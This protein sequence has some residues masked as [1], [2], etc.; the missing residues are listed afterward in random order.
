MVPP[1]VLTSASASAGWRSGVR[2]CS[3]STPNPLAATMQ[4]VSIQRREYPRPKKSPIVRNAPA[5]SN[6]G[7]NPETGRS[8][9]GDT[10]TAIMATSNSH[11]AARQIARNLWLEIG[12][13]L[14]CQCSRVAGLVFFQAYYPWDDAFQSALRR[15]CH[16]MGEPRSTETLPQPGV[17]RLARQVYL[18]AAR[19]VVKPSA[20]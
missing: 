17:G 14:F 8:V 5:R 2:N 13:K 9:I 11:P 7:A 1:L 19:A 12:I 20:S 3:A 6:P 10:V 16:P 15:A 4:S 18:Q